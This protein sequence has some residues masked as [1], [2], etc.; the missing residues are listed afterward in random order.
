ME[1]NCNPRFSLW[2]SQPVQRFLSSLLAFCYKV[3]FCSLVSQRQ[4]CFHVLCRHLLISIGTVF[5]LQIAYGLFVSALQQLQM[6]LSPLLWYSTMF[7]TTKSGNMRCLEIVW[8]QNRMSVSLCVGM[9][10]LQHIW[11]MSVCLSV[12]PDG[13]KSGLS[14]FGVLNLS[15]WHCENISC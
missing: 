8:D 13:N 11:C 7:R 3:Q 4:T 9:L 12:L 14:G 6:D 1:L 10:A 5:L 2:T 15:R